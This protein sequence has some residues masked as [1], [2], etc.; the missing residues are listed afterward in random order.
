MA[1]PHAETSSLTSPYSHS[2][3][4]DTWAQAN[5]SPSP[6]MSS[7]NPPL[8][9][10][11]TIYKSYA[12]SPRNGPST[13]TSHTHII[14]PNLILGPRP[15]RHPLHGWAQPT[16]HSPTH[17]SFT[18]HMW[19]HPAMAHQPRI[20][21]PIGPPPPITVYDIMLVVWQNSSP[22]NVNLRHFLPFQHLVQSGHGRQ[23]HIGGQATRCHLIPFKSCRSSKRMPHT[24]PSSSSTPTTNTVITWHQHQRLTT[25]HNG[26]WCQTQHLAV[27]RCPEGSDWLK[28]SQVWRASAQAQSWLAGAQER[29]YQSE[30]RHCGVFGRLKSFLT[31]V[32]HGSSRPCERGWVGWDR[33]E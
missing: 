26:A 17:Q 11:S 20:N 27:L 31:L 18:N 23:Q 32:G 25:W 30:A 15:I 2:P 4:S 12:T 13:L 16:H 9:R 29:S 7:T 19:T 3:Q 10:P 33:R 21:C 1:S 14:L 6:R 28:D 8:T 5:P 22:N 24:F